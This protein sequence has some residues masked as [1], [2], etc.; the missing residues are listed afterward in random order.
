[1]S[2]PAVAYTKALR[3]YLKPS[4]PVVFPVREDLIVATYFRMRLLNVRGFYVDI[5]TFHPAKVLE[6]PHLLHRAGWHGMSGLISIAGGCV[7]SSSARRTGRVH[8]MPY[9]HHAGS[10]R[11]ERST[12]SSRIWSEVD[13]I[14]HRDRGAVRGHKQVL[15]SPPRRS[16]AVT[17]NDVLARAP[18]VRLLEPRH[19]KDQCRGSPSIS[20]WRASDPGSFA[21]RTS[22]PTRARFSTHM[23]ISASPARVVVTSIARA[24]PRIRRGEEQAI[25]V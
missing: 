12:S 18:R 22:L 15:G 2:A 1:M 8:A 11:F 10:R 4:H 3:D 16:H 24:T 25:A 19:R 14:D 21:S 23:D 6:Q 5:G 17:I 7:R 20:T 9:G 13:T